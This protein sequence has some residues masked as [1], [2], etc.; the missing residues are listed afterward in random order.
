MSEL[1]PSIL[2]GIIFT[3]LGAAK[4]YGLTTGLV[5]GKDVQFGEKLCGT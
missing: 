3:L 1:I 5:G 4:V 2:V